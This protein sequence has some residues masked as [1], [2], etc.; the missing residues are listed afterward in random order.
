MKLRDTADLLG[1][2][3][4]G[5]KTAQNRIL[6]RLRSLIGKVYSNMEAINLITKWRDKTY[7]ILMVNNYF[8]PN[9]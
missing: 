9:L 6:L 2:T 3:W 7:Y 4:Y 5:L 8:S 1:Q